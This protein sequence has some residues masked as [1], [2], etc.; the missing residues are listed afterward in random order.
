MGGREERNGEDPERGNA[1][2]VA[3]HER[4]GGGGGRGKGGAS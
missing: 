3:H 1:L 4:G 2:K